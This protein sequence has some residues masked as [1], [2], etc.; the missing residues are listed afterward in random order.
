MV[1]AALF[2]LLLIPG[3]VWNSACSSGRPMKPQ[4]SATTSA[5]DS[6]NTANAADTAKPANVAN[7][8]CDFK[9]VAM[10]DPAQK[11]I[12]CANGD[13]F[14]LRR[15]E[16]NKWYEEMK[17]RAGTRPGYATPDEAGRARCCAPAAG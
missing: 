6:A 4:P 17:V 5:A 11:Q 16:D 8:P 1:R 10:A 13:S 9:I 14:V 7:T 15:G 12:Q 2:T 3:I